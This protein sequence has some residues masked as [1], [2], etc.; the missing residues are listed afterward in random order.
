MMSKFVKCIAI[1]SMGLAVLSCGDR[2]VTPSSAINDVAVVKE[3]IKSS[4]ASNSSGL[5]LVAASKPVSL[6]TYRKEKVTAEE[7]KFLSRYDKQKKDN[8]DYQRIDLNPKEIFNFLKKGGVLKVELK[9]LEP[10]EFIFLPEEVMD[11]GIISGSS[12]LQEARDTPDISISTD[13]SVVSILIR[14]GAA[15]FEISSTKK[16]GA[17]FVVQTDPAK[18]PSHHGL[19]YKPQIGGPPVEVPKSPPATDKK[20]LIELIPP[21]SETPSKKNV[22]SST[23]IR[24]GVMLTQTAFGD[25]SNT[26]LVGDLNRGIQW[27]RD[28]MT[29]SGINVTFT[30]AGTPEVVGVADAGKTMLSL[31]SRPVGFWNVTQFYGVTN[32]SDVASLW[33]SPRVA[34]VAAFRDTIRPFLSTSKSSGVIA[35]MYLLLNRIEL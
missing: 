14:I 26:D 20:P 23:D 22:T 31:F 17:H 3:P 19:D 32:V 24:I 1:I 10:R 13:G 33:R 18:R 15:E 5:V 6:F 9:G 12:R 16:G 28:A 27:L 25:V 35:P 11:F 7:A 21:A 8:V 34:E 2:D 4:D 29:F 30:L